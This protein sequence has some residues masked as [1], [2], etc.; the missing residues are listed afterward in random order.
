M[1]FAS[2]IIVTN[3][4]LYEKFKLMG[5]KEY[6]TLEGKHESGRG[7]LDDFF[8]KIQALHSVSY[9]PPYYFHLEHKVHIESHSC[10]QSEVPNTVSI[11]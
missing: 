8:C 3:Q 2:I 1:L 7:L 6:G 11:L 5:L 4:S 9:Y 10:S